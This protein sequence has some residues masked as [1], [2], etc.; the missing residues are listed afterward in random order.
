MGHIPD[1]FPVKM[2]KQEDL[3]LTKISLECDR[4]F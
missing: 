4:G 1:K 2:L 3:N